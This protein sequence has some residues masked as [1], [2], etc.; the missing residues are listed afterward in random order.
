M[1]LGPLLDAVKVEY[2]VAD[3]PSLV[4]IIIIGHLTSLAVDAFL[5]NVASADSTVVNLDI[6]LPHDNSVPFLDFIQLLG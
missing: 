6:P 3:T 1:I 5:H 2:M 4:T